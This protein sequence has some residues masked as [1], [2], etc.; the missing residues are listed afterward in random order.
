MFYD[1]DES[2]GGFIIAKREL[3]FEPEFKALYDAYGWNAIQYMLY[4]LTP[5]SPYFAMPEPQRDIQ[6]RRSVSIMPWQMDRPI[7]DRLYED[8]LFKLAEQRWPEFESWLEADQENTLYKLRVD[9]LAYVKTLHLNNPAERKE[10]METMSSLDSL[11]KQHRD[12]K[13]ALADRLAADD[14]VA[15]TLHDI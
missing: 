7:P 8:P 14:G 13:K 9:A 12:N 1:F 5:I 15:V 2:R 10:I 11:A 3:L 4:F 6:A